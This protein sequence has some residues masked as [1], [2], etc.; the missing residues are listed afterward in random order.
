MIWAK[1]YLSEKITAQRSKLTRQY[2]PSAFN[3][4]LTHLARLERA[5]FPRELYHNPGL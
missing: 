3:L 5:P 4:F 1:L 2:S